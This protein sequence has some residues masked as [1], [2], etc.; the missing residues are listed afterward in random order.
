MANRPTLAGYGY[1]QTRCAAAARAALRGAAS[2]CSSP[3]SRARPS[4]SN[5]GAAHVITEAGEPGDGAY[6]IVSG[7]SRAHRASRARDGAPEPIEPGSL[8]GEMAMLVE[9]VYRRHGRRQRSRA[10]PQDHARRRA[11]ADA[12]RMPALAR[13]FERRIRERLTRVAEDLRQIDGILAACGTGESNPDARVNGRV[14]RTRLSRMPARPTQHPDA[15]KKSAQP[16]GRSWAQEARHA[17]SAGRE[18]GT[19]SDV[20]RLDGGHYR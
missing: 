10:L 20:F 13:H 19:A 1:R 4:A 5:S 3:S 7:D 12:R 8:I 17:H 6:L 16:R 11:R 15:Q 14:R 9:H 18:A 2:R